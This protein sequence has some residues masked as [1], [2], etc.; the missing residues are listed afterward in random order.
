M[1]PILRSRKHSTVKG[2]D[3]THIQ[4]IL[5]STRQGRF[6]D[7]VARW[8]M[9][10]AQNSMPIT[11]ELAD[12]PL[13]FVSSPVPPMMAESETRRCS[14]GATRSPKPTA[15]CSSPPAEVFDEHLL[16]LQQVGVATI[17]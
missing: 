14:R 4:V 3:M 12:W 13:P 17:A 8:F 11:A 7:R 10:Q 5:G 16:S 15:T 2:N 1:P 9:Q 6:G